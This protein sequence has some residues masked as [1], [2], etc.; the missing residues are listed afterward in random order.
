MNTVETHLLQRYR[1]DRAP[2]ATKHGGREELVILVLKPLDGPDQAFAISKIDA[3]I[4]A[5]QLTDAAKDAQ[6]ETHKRG[7]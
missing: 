3:M 2:G 5:H 6:A 1:V 4:I 7:D